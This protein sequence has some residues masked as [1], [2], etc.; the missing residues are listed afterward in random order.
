[1]GDVTKTRKLFELVLDTGELLRGD[2]R[3]LRLPRPEGW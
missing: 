3:P 1:M 2:G